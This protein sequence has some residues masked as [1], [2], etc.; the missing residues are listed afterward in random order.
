MDKER[1]EFAKRLKHAMRAVGLDPR[2]SVLFL[3]FNAHYKGD[4][5]SFQTISRWL[6]GLALPGQDKVQTLASLLGIEPHVLRFGPGAKIKVGETG[7]A[8]PDA[9]DIHDRGMV[10][11]YLTLTVPQRKLVR[12]LVAALAGLPSR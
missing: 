9:F 1:D 11:A 10:D 7:S 5:V 8:W 4:S 3:Q 6:N 12:E 2:P